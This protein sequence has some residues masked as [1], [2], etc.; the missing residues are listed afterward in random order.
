MMKELQIHRTKLVPALEAHSQDR[1][2]SR[3]ADF[4]R[5]GFRV[6]G[7]AHIG[8]HVALVVEQAVASGGLRSR[9]W[10]TDP[11]TASHRRLAMSGISNPETGVNAP[12]LPLLPM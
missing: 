2:Q 4:A 11:I 9:G 1:R 8:E 5:R 6:I 3:S 12:T 10:P 7:H